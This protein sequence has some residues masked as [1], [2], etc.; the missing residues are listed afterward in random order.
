[1]NHKR[2]KK[3]LLLD[4]SKRSSQPWERGKK[5][6]KKG[7]PRYK[8]KIVRDKNRKLKKVYVLR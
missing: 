7:N 8:P 3:S 5:A 2:S 1:M 6:P 4:R